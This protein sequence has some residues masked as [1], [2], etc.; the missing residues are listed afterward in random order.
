MKKFISTIV[1]GALV[2]LTSVVSADVK[3]SDIQKHW[4]KGSIQWAIAHD[5]AVGYPDGTFKPNSTLTEAEFVAMLIRVYDNANDEY[6]RLKQADDAKAVKYHWTDHYY[7]VATEHNLPVNGGEHFALRDKPVTRG[8]VANIITS[9][10]GKNFYENESIAYLYD[11][12]LSNGK[13]AKT[14]AGFKPADYLTR[15]EA[16]QFLNALV[17]KKMDKEMLKRSDDHDNYP[18]VKNYLK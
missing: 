18:Y 15:A 11:K 12:G 8:V 17:I 4:A 3:F 13:N 14:I 7:V 1:V 2:L 6:T 5:L 10:L 16:V 9:A